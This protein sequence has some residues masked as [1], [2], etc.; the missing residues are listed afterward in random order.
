MTTGA[1]L[2]DMQSSSQIFTIN[3]PTPSFLQARCPACRQ[4]NSVKALKGIAQSGTNSITSWK[5]NCPLF[6]TL[7]I[8][9]KKKTVNNSTVA[10]IN[11][12]RN[13]L[14]RCK[15]WMHYRTIHWAAYETAE[16]R[17]LYWSVSA[18]I[19][20]SHNLK[21]NHNEFQIKSQSN[22]VHSN[23]IF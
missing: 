14:P 15:F 18:C 5:Q 20:M 13:Q 1:M 8:S 6:R 16:P 19:A 11:A 22:H 21:S 17:Q 4:T 7:N 2:S 3:K 23:R 12:S 9:L 10:N